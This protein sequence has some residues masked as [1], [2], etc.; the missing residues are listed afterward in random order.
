MPTPSFQA[1]KGRVNDFYF[2]AWKYL[3]LPHLKCGTPGRLWYHYSAT[4]KMKSLP[5]LA[6]GYDYVSERGLGYLSNVAEEGWGFLSLSDVVT[7]S[8]F[9]HVG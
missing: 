2:S 7:H 3:V 9:A 5:C 8:L 6:K 1:L 4:K